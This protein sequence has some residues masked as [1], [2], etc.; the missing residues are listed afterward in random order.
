[1]RQVLGERVP[2][3]SGTLYSLYIAIHW[4]DGGPRP[5]LLS[6]STWNRAAQPWCRKLGR[7]CSQELEEEEG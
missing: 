6:S 1:M 5:A 3:Q 7:R 4:E 2:E